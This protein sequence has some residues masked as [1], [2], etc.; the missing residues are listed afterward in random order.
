M[1]KQRYSRETEIEA[2]P[3]VVFAWHE[4][5]GAVERLTPPWERVEMVERASD[6]RVG[7]RVVFR[8]FM[9]PI[10]QIWV[11]EHTVYEPPHLFEDVQRQGPFASWV[12]RHRFERTAR[13]TTRM[14]DEVEYELPM[15][16]L[17]EVFG[18]G[19]TRRK[20]ERMFE[21]RHRVVAE[22]FSGGK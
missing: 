6:L 8:V 14:I 10:G 5:A 12:H 2:S 13:N 17:G 11:A 16:W 18:G 7:A 9:G 4:E 21:Y 19:F 1:G 15:G 20:L 22:A 3:E